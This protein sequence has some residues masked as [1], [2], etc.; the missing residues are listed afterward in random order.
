M[1]TILMEDERRLKK[2]G[3][4]LVCICVVL[5]SHIC[6]AWG[7]RG[8][9]IVTRV[10]VRLLPISESF[11]MTT[12]FQRREFML[13][14]LSNVPD[15][16]WRA[17]NMSRKERGL[18][19]PTHYINLDA[20]VDNPQQIMDFSL[21]YHTF[22]DL[23]KSKGLNL[24]TNVGTAPWRVEQLHREMTNALISA[25]DSDSAEFIRY[26]NQA[27][28]YAGIMGHFVADLANPHHT[29]RN[30]DGYLTGNGGLH[31]YFET[32]VVNELDLTLAEAVILRGSQPDYLEEQL[33]KAHPLSEH[34][35]IRSDPLKL[36]FALVLNSYQNL[37]RLHQ[38]DKQHSIITQ[39]DTG[40]RP[41]KRKPARVVVDDYREFVIERLAIGS[42]VLSELWKLAWNSAGE[43]DLSSYHSFVYPVRPD[44]IYPDYLN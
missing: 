6:I 14:H 8:H 12:P 43:P 42:A 15:I 20:V 3:T 9:N 26:V 28:L 32:H 44:F 31:A 40:N 29:T 23:A 30:H 24:V 17:D 16:V 5:F 21:G 10:A 41:A 18:N 35:E 25:R 37:D 34:G 38:L 4:I 2:T 22:F 33:L 1:F 36:I 39:S 13:A 7:E 11:Q 19:S 27:L